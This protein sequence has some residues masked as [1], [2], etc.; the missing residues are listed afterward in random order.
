MGTE[1]RDANNS[2]RIIKSFR[3]EK[4][5]KIPK[6]KPPYLQH[7]HCPHPSVPHLHGSGTPLGTVIPSCSCWPHCQ[8]TQAI[9]L[10][11]HLG[12]PVAHIQQLLP[13]APRPFPQHSSQPV[14]PTPAGPGTWCVEAHPIGLSPFVLPWY[15]LSTAALW[16][17]Q[18]CQSRSVS[19]W[20]L[21]W[22]HCNYYKVITRWPQPKRFFV[23]FVWDQK[24]QTICAVML[25]WTHWLQ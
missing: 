17:G 8:L 12:T 18:C 15:K 24:I 2:H 22:L 3:L 11:G 16:E 6:S 4:T 20:W 23:P 19:S 7:A 5:P 25:P 21:Q 10:L 9:G 13:N 1:R 14:C